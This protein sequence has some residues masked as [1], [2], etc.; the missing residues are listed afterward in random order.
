ML[1]DEPNEHSEPLDAVLE[2]MPSKHS[3]IIP[4]AGSLK[5]ILK[6]GPQRV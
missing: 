5:E 6:E 3:A 2:R 1:L 4:S